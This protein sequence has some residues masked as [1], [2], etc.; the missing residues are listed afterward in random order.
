MLLRDGRQA[1]LG[2]NNGFCPACLGFLDCD[3]RW[4]DNERVVDT[5]VGGF[6]KEEDD[7]QQSGPNES[8]SDPIDDAPSMVD[9]DQA[10]DHGTE[11]NPY[12]EGC[13]VEPLYVFSLRIGVESAMRTYAIYKPRSWRKKMSQMVSG[14]RHSP[15]PP[16][17]PKNN[18]VTISPP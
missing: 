3:S 6:G 18:L 9:G 7:T 5:L 4:I 10:C 11:G 2:V 1:R 15:A 12:G 14:A 16:A 13:V 17:R 8:C